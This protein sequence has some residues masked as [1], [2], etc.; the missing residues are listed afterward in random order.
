MGVT[1]AVAVTRSRSL[2]S[3]KPRHPP[4]TGESG[5][6]AGAAHANKREHPTAAPAPRASP[7]RRRPC[8][9]PHPCR[10]PSLRHHTHLCRP[11]N[12]GGDRATT[13][14]RPNAQEIPK[15]TRREGKTRCK[16]PAN[17]LPILLPRKRPCIATGLKCSHLRL[18]GAMTRTEEHKDCII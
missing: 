5:Q 7:C 4:N 10:R 15:D 14:S 13:S 12:L 2:S 9:Q 16:D 17:P 1:I 6:D 11:T 3:N 8:S 18:Q